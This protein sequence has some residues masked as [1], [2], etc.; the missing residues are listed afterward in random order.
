[1]CCTALPQH[2]H[3]KPHTQS[4]R[5]TGVHLRSAPSLFISEHWNE[6]KRK[7]LSECLVTLLSCERG[8]SVC[9]PVHY[10]PTLPSTPV[11]R[12]CTSASSKAAKEAIIRQQH[13][14][15]DFLT[16]RLCQQHPT[17]WCFRESL[18]YIPVPLTNM[19]NSKHVHRVIWY[20]YYPPGDIFVLFL[21]ALLKQIYKLLWESREIHQETLLGF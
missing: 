20:S 6:S 18:D 16:F 13:H 5:H 4:P 1:M 15:W 3:A 7:F 14:C 9:T 2:P 19:I 21:N 11:L 17:N 8:R 12:P 10:C